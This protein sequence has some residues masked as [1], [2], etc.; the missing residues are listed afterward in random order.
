MSRKL[1]IPMALALSSAAC[2]PTEDITAQ[3]TNV[4]SVGSIARLI[5]ALSGK[6][7]QL[8]DEAPLVAGTGN[9]VTPPF[10]PIDSVDEPIYDGALIGTRPGDPMAE[11]GCVFL[12]EPGA[13]ITKGALD[14]ALEH[15]IRWYDPEGWE[16]P[17]TFYVNGVNTNAQA[18][19][20]TLRAIAE[21][22]NSE[23]MRVI[24]IF[25]STDGF[26]ADI[27]QVTWDRFS[28]NVEQTLSDFGLGIL[29]EMHH[30]TAADSVVNVLLHRARA[31]ETTRF[32][33]HSQGGAITSLA[34]FRA[35]RLLADEGVWMRNTDGSYLVDH[36]YVNT[37]GS[38][39]PAW[40][41]L[42]TQ[43]DDGTLGTPISHTVHIRDAT[44]SVFGIAL[45]N[46]N[47]DGVERTGGGQVQF[48][49]SDAEGTYWSY[50][51][52][53]ELETLDIGFLDLR[54]TTFHSVEAYTRVIW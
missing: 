24:G 33:A 42:L 40:P 51:E 46:W 49:D 31:S 5:K 23:G 1:I 43:Y 19:C 9:A 18:H 48:M 13:P 7:Y 17:L 45:W 37:Y 3:E 10:T 25:N 39:A 14:A 52:D 44:P 28:V 32:Q 21:H 11:Q 54:P 38:A 6:L 20:D 8:A 12:T 34:L 53:V 47:E 27:W 22:G 35:A 41:H 36:I 15:T 50:V 4:T 16:F 2:G 29:S 26:A 30:N